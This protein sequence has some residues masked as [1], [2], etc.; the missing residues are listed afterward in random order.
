M[1]G[2]KR[3]DWAGLEREYYLKDLQS[4][5]TKLIANLLAVKEK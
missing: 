4:G 5:L 1:L 3:L 2:I